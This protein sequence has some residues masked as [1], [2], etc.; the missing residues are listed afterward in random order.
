MRIQK[1]DFP[2]IIPLC[3]AVLIFL[4]ILI[5]GN[6]HKQDEVVYPQSHSISINL[7]K[8][9][10][11]LPEKENIPALSYLP[12]EL[13]G[14]IVGKTSLA[15][16]SNTETEKKGIFK[17]NDFVGDYKLVIIA[18]GKVLLEKDGVKQEL[19]LV[20]HNAKNEEPEIYTDGSGIT[21]VSRALIYRQ[22]PK[23]N[24]LLAKLKIFPIPEAN[25]VKFRGFRV[26]NVPQGSIIEEVGIKSGDVIYS[27]EGKELQSTQ[28][29]WD[30]F[31]T[32]KKQSRFEIVLLRNDKPVTLKYQLKN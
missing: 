17:L 3:I 16:I 21:T 20:G 10:N 31:N 1:N 11:P 2:W 18:S 30:M 5:Q 24:E 26:D 4:N 13:Q 7:P 28:D 19:L 8:P 6:F 9:V 29:A 12:F 15:F 32:V 22:L 14:T 23:A 25:S 27:V